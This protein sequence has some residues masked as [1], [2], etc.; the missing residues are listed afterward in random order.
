MTG[1]KVYI[2][3]L[4]KGN[5]FGD[6]IGHIYA[7]VDTLCADSAM[8]ELRVFDVISGKFVEKNFLATDFAVAGYR[9]FGQ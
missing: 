8:A 2:M 9:M 1:N 5:M 3:N 4:K 7:Y 6:A